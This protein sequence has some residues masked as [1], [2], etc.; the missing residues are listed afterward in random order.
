MNEL[1]KDIYKIIFTREIQMAEQ[2]KGID[3]LT[4]DDI[5][6]LSRLNIKY[7]KIFYQIALDNLVNNKEIIETYSI[8]KRYYTLNVNVE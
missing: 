2:P 7:S 4:I 3:G 5:I 8:G 6:N 1:E